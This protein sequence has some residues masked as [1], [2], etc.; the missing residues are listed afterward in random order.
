MSKIILN[1]RLPVWLAQIRDCP[2]N[3]SNLLGSPTFARSV[4]PW[5]WAVTMVSGVFGLAAFFGA[6]GV[7]GVLS[8]LIFVG[9]A[10]LSLAASKTLLPSKSFSSISSGDDDSSEMIVKELWLISLG[11]SFD[12]RRRFSLA[13]LSSV[14]VWDS[15]V[16]TMSRRRK[17]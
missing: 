6:W 8:V 1:L 17:F 5:I 14:G 9:V 12:K 3:T 7:F 11:S 10:S 15:V 2:H 4:F 16:E 13:L